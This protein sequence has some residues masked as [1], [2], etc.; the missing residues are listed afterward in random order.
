VPG[1]D[2]VHTPAGLDWSQRVMHL[3]DDAA[4]LD[5]VDRLFRA[6]WHRKVGRTEH[7]NDYGLVVVVHELGDLCGDEPGATPRWVSIVVR[8]GAAHKIGMLYGSQRP[9]NIPRVARTE[10][11]HTISMARG[12]DPE[13]TVIVAKM[14]RMTVPEFERALGQASQ[15]GDRSALWYDKRARKNVILPQ[16]PPAKLRETL[17]HGIDS[18][19]DLPESSRSE[20]EDDTPGDLQQNSPGELPENVHSG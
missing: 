1:V 7:K 19:T 12:L 5:E 20:L 8:K 13:D 2:A 4:D 18:P 14:H 11:M 17:A 15:S 3:I 9:R 6:I 10:A 16:L